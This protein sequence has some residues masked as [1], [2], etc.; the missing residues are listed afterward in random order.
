MSKNIG[1][2]ISTKELGLLEHFVQNKY[3]KANNS[4]TASALLADINE[5]T[6]KSCKKMGME[7]EDM[8]TEFISRT[9]MYRILKKFQDNGILA[10]GIKLDTAKTYYIT[11]E[12]VQFYASLIDLSQS[13]TDNLLKAYEQINGR[14]GNQ[15][16]LKVDKL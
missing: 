1:L 9:V 14:W 7:E 5:E 13:D 10:N 11:L 2:S 4:I 3:I 15:F 16:H 6:E 12:G 8:K